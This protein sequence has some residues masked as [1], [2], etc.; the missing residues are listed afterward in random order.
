MR[1]I[2]VEP[3]RF[4]LYLVEEFYRKAVV[5]LDSKSFRTKVYSTRLTISA[6]FLTNEFGLSNNG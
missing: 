6:Q 5:A 4:H 1:F 2:T 3:E